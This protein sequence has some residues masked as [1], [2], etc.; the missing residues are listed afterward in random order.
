MSTP[1]HGYL[2][3]PNDTF[4]SCEDKFTRT[5][6]EKKYICTDCGSKFNKSLIGSISSD[7]SSLPGYHT[8]GYMQLPK[9]SCPDGNPADY[10][11]PEN[12]KQYDKVTVPT[13]RLSSKDFYQKH[14]S[15]QSQ[16]VSEHLPETSQQQY[17]KVSQERRKARFEEEIRKAEDRIRLQYEQKDYDNQ[18]QLS[19]QRLS[20][21][22]IPQRLPPP[23]IPQ[24]LPPPSNPKRSRLQSQISSRSRANSRQRDPPS[25]S[26][27]TAV[28]TMI[29][30]NTPSQQSNLLSSNSKEDDDIFGI[31]II[32][33]LILLVGII[34]ML[35]KIFSQS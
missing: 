19:S 27:R 11:C 7:V 9:E 1:S 4:S 35:K 24:R 26:S 18:Q 8:D 12:N 23:S 29:N 30:N 6:D 32:I 3:C 17:Q 5:H 2:L 13:D 33:G 16:N 34:M 15:A 31:I 10:L 28:K 22:S 25:L 20:P 21:P 14:S